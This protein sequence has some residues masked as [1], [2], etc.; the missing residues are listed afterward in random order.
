[1]M[2]N[3]F[4]LFDKEI[5]YYDLRGESEY[6]IRGQVA[7]WYKGPK[8]FNLFY[9]DFN[10][11]F[12]NMV[13]GV[14]P[15]NKRIRTNLPNL[16]VLSFSDERAMAW[17]EELVT[18]VN[19]SSRPFVSSFRKVKYKEI[20]GKL[21]KGLKKMVKID[22]RIDDLVMVPLKGGSYFLDFLYPE[23]DFSKVLAVDCKRI[24]ALNKNAF[25][26]GIRVDSSDKYLMNG[27]IKELLAGEKQI[28][29]LR[30]V[31]LCIVSGMTTVGYLL[32]LYLNNIRPKEIEIDTIAM[33]QQG[34]EMIDKLAKFLG[35]NV[36]FVTGGLFYRL[37][38]F[39]SSHMDEL[40]TIDGK[41]IIGDVKKF[42][43]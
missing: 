26:Y 14:V 30:V 27:K 23:G 4:K 41:L 13:G 29:K 33:S 35:I 6:K 39:Y 38:N 15:E 25:S 7:K 17:L 43:N 37:G 24:P 22:P 42:L 2:K 32:Y 36:I 31:E 10:G 9:I 28:N 5:E 20:L 8:S 21:G 12:N 3:S 11:F 40:L 18:V 34:Y 19:Y 16:K 1:M